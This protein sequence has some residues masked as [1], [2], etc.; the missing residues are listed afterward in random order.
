MT[1]KTRDDFIP[2]VGGFLDGVS[3]DIVE[4]TFEIAS[5]E[6]A[7]RVMAEGGGKAKPGVMLK[8]T[9]ESPEL[10]RPTEQSFSVGAA[11]LWEIAGDGK[12]ITNVKNADKHIFR[13]GSRAWSLVE[14]MMAAVGEGKLEKGQ[15]FFIGRDTYMTQA[16][17]YEGLGFYWEVKQLPK[18]DP[19]RPPSNVPLPVKFLGKTTGGTKTAAPEVDTADLDLL[20]VANATGKTVTELKTWAI[21]DP[22]IKGNATYKAEIV[23]GKKLKELEN[24]GQ[25]T[26]GADKKYA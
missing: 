21:K 19:T 22:T 18:V 10:E 12:S 16:T 23:S 6:Y 8:L 4:A 11:D 15:D 3:G 24:A 25:L 1:P 5:G 9:I 2:E 20:V 17:F 7:D 26:M 13:K 14:A